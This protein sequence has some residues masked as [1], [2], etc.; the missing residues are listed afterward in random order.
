MDCGAVAVMPPQPQDNM[1]IVDKVGNNDKR[2][3]RHRT[4]QQRQV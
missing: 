2:D 3:Q 4:M 1:M